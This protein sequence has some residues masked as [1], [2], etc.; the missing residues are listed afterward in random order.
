MDIKDFWYT[1]LYT[2][3][4]KYPLEF[5]GIKQEK[6]EYFA[7]IHH[8]LACYSTITYIHIWDGWYTEI[9]S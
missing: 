5:T 8:K 2:F 3:I 9:Q 7:Y 4:H 6:Y 1:I